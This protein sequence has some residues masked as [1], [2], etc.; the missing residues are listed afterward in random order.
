MIMSTRVYKNLVFEGGGIRGLAFIGAL[1]S[2]N[3][4]DKIK[5]ITHIAGTSVGSI[6][7]VLAGCKCSN[8]ELDAYCNKFFGDFSKI[9]S[10]I[11]REGLNFYSNLG[12]HDNIC[13]YNSINLFLSGKFGINNM[14][15]SQYYEKTGV[16]ITIVGT[17][18]TTRSTVYLNH[19]SYPDME[20]AKAVQIS[21]AI[22]I[23]F[24]VVKWDNKSWVDGGVVDNFPIDYYDCNNGSYNNETLGL[25]LQ[26][27]STNHSK[28]QEYPVNNLLDLLEGIEDIQLGDNIQQSIKDPEKRNIVYIDTGSISSINFAITDNDKKFLIDNGYEATTNFL[29]KSSCEPPKSFLRSLINYVY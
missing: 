15:F 19:K 13:V 3:D 29:N 1:K 16:D 11:I 8:D 27:S 7:T 12:I 26:P 28:D 24:N 20:V 18:M 6:F 2:I 5:H 22:P 17:C 9:N 14:T 4:L 10:G 25:F 21:T 23:F